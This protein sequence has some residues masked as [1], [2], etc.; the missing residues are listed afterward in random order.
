MSTAARL[1]LSMAAKLGKPERAELLFHPQAT[2]DELKACLFVNLPW[3]EK[4]MLWPDTTP[5]D[6][7]LCRATKRL[8]PRAREAEESVSA[9]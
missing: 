4:A 6:M 9:W 5:A 3:Y 8:L 2:D 1:I 7:D